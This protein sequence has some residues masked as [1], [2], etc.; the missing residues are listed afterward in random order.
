MK[1]FKLIFVMFVTLLIIPVVTNAE[2]IIN[3]NGIE[4]SEEDYNNFSKV[5]SHEYLMTMTQE[6]YDYLKTLDFSGVKKQTKYVETTYN[7]SLNLITERE[8]TK[9]EYNASGSANIY[10]DG[11][12]FSTTSKTIEITL[13]AGDVWHHAVVS[14]T[15][16]YIL[17]TRSFDVIGFRGYD[18]EFRNGSQSGEQIYV[19]NGNYKTINYSWDG[20][21]IKRLDNGFGISMNIVNNTLDGLQL[22]TECDVKATSQYPA[23]YGSYQHAVAN[24]TLAE[25]QNYTLSGEGLGGV[26]VY[27]YSILDKYDGMSGVYLQY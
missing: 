8:L 1:N 22:W 6:K 20:T 10:S 7:P 11:Q 3:N 2:S 26:F 25:S 15:W 13:I 14:S 27:P 24:V 16:K 5:Y 18:F 9:E 12:A 19:E 4:I 23:I 21:N 17:K